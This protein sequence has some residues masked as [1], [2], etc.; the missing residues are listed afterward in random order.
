MPWDFVAIFLV[1]GILLPWKGYTRLR[2]LLAMPQITALDRLS[3]YASTIAFQWVAATIVA[4]RSWAHGFTPADLGFLPVNR[5]SGVL[6][7]T[8]L[9]GLALFFVQWL[10]V[11]RMSRLPPESRGR[12]QSLAEHIL[13]HTNLEMLVFVA[14]CVSAAVCE[15]FIYRGFAIA[16]LARWGWPPI[17]TI[18]ATSGLFALG[19]LYQGR[20]GVLTTLIL[21]VLFSC[22]RLSYDGLF[23]VIAWHGS[24]DVAAGFAGMR[25]LQYNELSR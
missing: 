19:H 22:V 20:R 17:G 5:R 1:L 7:A 6:L 24:I 13:P 16:A 25:Y 2:S 23:P 11:R 21:G 4:W 15:E 3:L 8:V 9:G 18:A 10:N 14:L 12:M